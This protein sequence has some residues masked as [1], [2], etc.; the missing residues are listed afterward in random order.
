MA[1]RS[2]LV[3]GSLGRLGRAV[4]QRLASQG[5]DVV[6]TDLHG[7]QLEGGSPQSASPRGSSQSL[8]RYV[9]ADLRDE[10]QVRALLPWSEIEDVVHLA[11]FPG[12]SSDPPPGVSLHTKPA[13]GLEE[14]AQSE[15]LL[16]NIASS[17]NVLSS[18]ARAE[19]RRVVFSSSAFSMGYAHDPFAFVPDFLP[20]DE[21]HPY[22]CHETYGLSK[23]V[24]EMICGL[25]SRCKNVHNNPIPLGHA[26]KRTEFVSLAFTNI[27]KRENFDSL[28]WPNPRG[29]K[30]TEANVKDPL[31]PLMWAY[32]HEDDVIDAHLSALNFTFPENGDGCHERFLLAADDTRFE[33]ETMELLIHHFKPEV[34]DRIRLRSK[35][36]WKSPFFSL[37]DNTKA[38]S[39]L[40]WKPRSWRTLESGTRPRIARNTTENIVR[41]HSDG[42]KDLL[43]EK[44]RTQNGEAVEGAF[45][46]FKVYG[47]DGGEK[48]TILV[49]TSFDAT[50][51][52]IAYHIA[53]ENGTKQGTFDPSEYRIIVSNHFGNGMSYS[54]TNYKEMG[55]AAYP[56]LPFTMTDNAHAHAQVLDHLGVKKLHLA[57]GYSM[58]AAQA[59]HLA[60][61][62]PDM[63]E[64]VC[65]VAGGV[66]AFDTNK[67]FLES[68]RHCIFASKGWDPKRYWFAGD[69]REKT[70]VLKAI[71]RIY[72]G[73][74][75]SA[76]FYESKEYLNIGFESL[77]DF[78]NRSYEKGFE[79][80]DIN[81][82]LAQVDTWL[83]TD[84]AHADAKFC[85]S[86]SQGMRSITANVLWMPVST[87]KYFLAE[88]IKKQAELF[89]NCEVKVIES[90]WGHRAGDPSRPGQEHQL[91]FIAKAVADLCA[92]SP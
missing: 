55:S 68:L 48:P 65:A 66:V 84:L 9:Q 92:Q 11:A 77:E 45:V 29:L 64:R 46:R 6:A 3:T 25:L 13:I 61:L 34:L 79:A 88:P 43:L 72:A 54:P 52:D 21:S 63:V 40:G 67:I 22:L 10:E 83:H 53:G 58:G 87:D 26:I 73:W 24:G 38:K 8:V 51:N 33:A 62:Y 80:C 59:F 47:D 49:M 36:E 82:L 75:V 4:V 81:N 20:M 39:V 78:S 91:K 35:V 44:F 60:A 5:R 71:A 16:G 90:I 15:L 31:T 69:V 19:A 12:P 1:Q 30:Q 37:I 89:D 57:Y 7:E 85:G 23:A 18:A 41:A 86:L 74:G 50:H 42:S 14:V 56:M 28:P 2:T 70:D 27:V 76:A 32:C 17:W